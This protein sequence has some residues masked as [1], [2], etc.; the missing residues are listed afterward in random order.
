MAQ[1]ARLWHGPASAALLLLAF[2]PFNLGLLV[3]VALVPWLLWLRE[4]EGRH[5]FRSGYLFGLVYMLGQMFWLLPF[6]SRW[7]GTSLLG[8]LPWLLAS[9]AGAVYF[10]LAGWLMSICWRRNWPWLV[11]IAWAGVEVFRSYIPVFAFPWG[12]LA[13]PLWPYPQVIQHAYYGTIFLVSASSVFASLA[14]VQLM[15]GE[16]FVRARPAAFAFVGLLMLSLARFGSPDDGQ[17][18]PIVIGQTGADMAFGEPMAVE[19]TTAESVERFYATTVLAG[20]RFLLLPEGI[21]AGGPAIPP[22]TPFE[23]RADVPVVFGGQRGV[24]PSYQST[25]A[26]DGRW[27]YADK[28]RLVIFGEFVPGRDWIPFLSAFDLPAGDLQA[29][30]R[31]QSLEVAGVRVGPLLCFEA[32]FPDIAYRQALQGVQMLAVLSIDDWYMGTPAPDQLKAASI[33][34]AVETGLPL[35]R[36]AS[37]GHT[38]AVD[39]RGGM[40]TRA[41]LGESVAIRAEFVLM[42]D[43]APFPGLPVF[44]VV[45]L[46]GVVL[47]PAV[48]VLLRRRCARPKGS[49][50]RNSSDGI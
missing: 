22:E 40:I 24:D 23:V 37:L 48:D 2:P 46:L 18:V 14:I 5:A 17:V 29:G 20:G 12:L 47:I 3:F 8:A 21:T 19:R 50:A 44:P 25:F 27:S 16:G 7:T 11:P 34:R 9:A 39:A 15:V 4:S 45:A 31:V 26:Y 13:T 32:L 38:F 35:A 33:W 10:G 1:V 36:S 41:P 43:P 42:P 28:T 49:A 30:E 6:V